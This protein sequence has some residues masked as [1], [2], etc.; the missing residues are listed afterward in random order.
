MDTLTTAPCVRSSLMWGIATG[1][2]V[3]G[4]RFRTTKSVRNAC[5]VAVLGFGAVAATS[6]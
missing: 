6:W 4:H 2:L 5:D 1:V 3:G